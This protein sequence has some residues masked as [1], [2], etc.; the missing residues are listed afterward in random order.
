MMNKQPAAW[1]ACV[2][3]YFLYAVLNLGLRRLHGVFLFP[4]LTQVLKMHQ[5]KIAVVGGP[6]KEM[7]SFN[8]TDN[9][10]LVRKPGDKGFSV[11][12]VTAVSAWGLIF[13]AFKL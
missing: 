11:Y 13:L 7:I 3:L 2:C 5:V 12:P 10:M 1:E 4:P 6:Q 9:L 8:N